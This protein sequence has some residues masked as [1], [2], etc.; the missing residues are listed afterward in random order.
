[1]AEIALKIALYFNHFQHTEILTLIRLQS[2]FFE[3]DKA[4]RIFLKYYKI[5]RE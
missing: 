3:K 2:Y 5:V 4:Y 1:M